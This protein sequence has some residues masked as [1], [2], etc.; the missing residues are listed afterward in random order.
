MYPTTK[1]NRV[2]Y[3]M[4][5]PSGDNN[6]ENCKTEPRMAQTGLSWPKTELSAAQL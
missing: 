6:L 4:E 3:L 1:K 5:L 2:I